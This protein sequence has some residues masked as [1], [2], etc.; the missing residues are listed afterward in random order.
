M[1]KSINDLSPDIMTDI[2]PKKAT[3]YNLRNSNVLLCA[4]RRTTTF[5]LKSV[6]FIANQLWKT[7]PE[8]L[9]KTSNLNS[10]KTQIKNWNGDNCLCPI[11]KTYISNIGF[12]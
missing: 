12:I 9:K 10:F 1:F 4:N 6:G 11:C 2:F 7:L 5:G 3:Q 8:D